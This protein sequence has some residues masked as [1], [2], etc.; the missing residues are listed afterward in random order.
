MKATALL[1]TAVVAAGLNTPLQAFAA[2]AE[3]QAEVAARGAEVMP[4]TVD[5]AS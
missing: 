5:G 2:D 4:F 3:R 1:A